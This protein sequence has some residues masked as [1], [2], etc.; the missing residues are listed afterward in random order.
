[1]TKTV[2]K[3]LLAT[4]QDFVS[5]FPD[6]AVADSDLV[7]SMSPGSLARAFKAEGCQ[8]PLVRVPVEVR[9]RQSQRSMLIGLTAGWPEEKQWE[10]LEGVIRELRA[11]APL[12]DLRINGRAVERVGG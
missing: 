8:H 10:G 9:S 4:Q 6:R 2:V 11:M 12:V 3:W 1:M 7:E 5:P